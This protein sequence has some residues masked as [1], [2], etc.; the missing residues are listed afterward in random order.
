MS[1]I[2]GTD[3]SIN[4]GRW[5]GGLRFNQ[6]TVRLLQALRHRAPAP[7]ADSPAVHGHDGREAAKGPRHKRLSRAIDLQDG[8]GS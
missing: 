3:I 5:L 1:S 7:G 6:F 2:P 8:C 4:N